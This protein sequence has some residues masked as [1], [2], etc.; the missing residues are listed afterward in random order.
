LAV[1]VN[2]HGKLFH[3]KECP[4]LNQKD[5]IKAMTAGEAAKQGYVPCPRCLGEY[6]AQVA[7]QQL[8]RATAES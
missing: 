3:V 2:T 4:F 8:Q 5:E 7:A 6:L 1:L